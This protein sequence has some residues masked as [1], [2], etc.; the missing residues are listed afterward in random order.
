[1]NDLRRGSQVSPGQVERRLAEDRRV[2]SVPYPLLPQS[3]ACLEPGCG[4]DAFGPGWAG[5]CLEHASQHQHPMVWRDPD[6]DQP[7]DPPVVALKNQDGEVA[8]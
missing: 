5:R 3:G 8:G 6:L 4:W 7:P 1:M 2:R